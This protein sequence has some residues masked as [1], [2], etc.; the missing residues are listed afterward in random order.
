LSSEHRSN[1]ETKAKAKEEI[2]DSE[3]ERGGG[4]TLG[5]V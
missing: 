4:R 1:M 5:F 3:E 2:S